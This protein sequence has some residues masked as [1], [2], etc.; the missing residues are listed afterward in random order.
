[1][2]RPQQLTILTTDQCTAACGHCS[3][4]SSPE[5]RGRLSREDMCKAMTDAHAAYGLLTV[6]F[7]GG[8]PTLLGEALLDCIAHADGLGINTRIVTNASWA[9]NDKKARRKIEELRW[10][11][12]RELNI[13]A[14]DQ[15][16][17][18]VPFDNII[19]A[20][21]AA[22]GRGFSSVVIANCYGP[23]SRIT[24]DF[25]EDKTGE[26]LERRFDGAGST[27]PLPAPAA[28][29]TVYMISNSL[30]QHLG[31]A[32]NELPST[33]IIYPDSQNELEGGCPWAV[34]SPALT[35][36]NHLAV[37]CGIE[38]HGNAVLDLGDIGETSFAELIEQAD[39]DV[40][41]NAIALM[42][43]MYLKR[44]IQAYDPSVAFRERYGS[45][46][47][48]CEDIVTRTDTLRA[49]S[50][51]MP[52]LAAQVI[53]KREHEQTVQDAD[54]AETAAQ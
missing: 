32:H 19:R 13:S 2:L 23:D 17:P 14:D 1:M 34:N 6:V 35:A 29:G 48:V 44:V 11:G 7:A 40:L 12:L 15:H 21:H 3:M 53:A 4:N 18:F 33:D 52:G 46:C 22:K 31:R 24:P 20:W 38:A 27:Q 9:I 36:G 49:L 50:M 41:L 25:I 39:Q 28:D 43:P 10:A 37:C 16:E 26:R 8:E 42:G 5:R 54:R 45:V 51:C 47:Q 30:T